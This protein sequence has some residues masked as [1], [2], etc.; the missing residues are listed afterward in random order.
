MNVLPTAGHNDRPGP[1]RVL[2]CGS[3]RGTA[4]LRVDAVRVVESARQVSLG[5]S[6]LPPGWVPPRLDA[7]PGVP[8]ADADAAG[9]GIAVVPGPPDWSAS[10]WYAP[11]D[12]SRSGPAVM[13][14]MLLLGLAALTT[15]L[16]PRP[17]ETGQA[18]TSIQA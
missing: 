14:A 1:D 4:E 9:A 16:F 11:I 6:G 5:P 18:W 12:W 10:M 3:P 15:A 13:A 7:S 8:S 2:S 17:I